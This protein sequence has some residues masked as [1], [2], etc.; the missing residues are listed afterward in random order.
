MATSR[1]L[2]RGDLKPANIKVTPDGKIKV[3]DFGLAKAFAGDGADAGV[4]NSPTLSM[5]A[6]QQGVILGTAAYMSPEQAR[7]ESTDKR[8]DIW[9]FGVVLF[10]MLTGRGTFDGRTVSDVLA[11]VLRADPDWRG[12]PS[13]LHPR[14]QFLL[15]RCLEKESK[16]R[17]GDIS[18][19][20]V[21]IQHVLADPDGVIVQPVTEVVQ[22]SQQ[23]KLRWVA[24]VVLTGAVAVI[25][26]W[27]LTPPPTPGPVSRWAYELVGG[28]NNA[29][30]LKS[31]LS[32]SPDGTHF[33]YSTIEGIYLRAVDRLDAG[34][35]P[36]TEGG[37]NPFF[38]PDGQSVG[39]WRNGQIETIPISGGRPSPVGSAP[40][41][42]SASWES[43]DMIL[44]A[45]YGGVYGLPASGGSPERIIESAAGE[46]FESPRLLPDG[47]GIL[48]SIS[49]GEDWDNA[50]IVVQ[51]L[52]AAERTIVLRGSDARYVSTGH[53]IYALD[54]GLYAIGFDLETLETIGSAEL[55][56]QGLS[57]ALASAS[58]NYGVSATGTL[59]YLEGGGSV[60]AGAVGALVWVNREGEEEAVGL[61][62]DS[63]YWTRLSSDG[64][65]L[66]LSIA[67]AGSGVQD[68][69]TSD[70]TR[71]PPT[72][73]KLT[74]TTSFDNMPIWTP[75]GEQ[76]VFASGRDGGLGFY[77]IHLGSGQV[78]HLIKG[79]TV[80]FLFPYDWSEDGA[81]LV[82]GYS[83]ADTGADVGVLS[84]EDLQWEPL[85]ATAANEW[86]PA[87]SPDGAWIAYT[88][89]R[90]SEPA[91]FVDSFPTPGDV[92]QISTGGGHAPLW[93]DDGRELFYRRNSDGAIITVSV[94]TGPIFGH[95]DPSVLIET[96]YA[97][98][99][100]GVPTVNYDYDT[101]R[102]RFLMVKEDTAAEEN[103]GSSAEPRIIVVQ[104]FFE[105]LKERV[106]VP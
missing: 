24:A 1:D 79:N 104:N 13:H 55:L 77:S 47:K 9:A 97:D 25:G 20:R 63:Y 27:R 50:Q 62:P 86:Q 94:E 29:S 105:E 99:G 45:Q 64:T 98:V 102:Q 101:Q 106:P 49:E 84:M 34:L 52:D 3:L 85:L 58:A 78:E 68:V 70:L 66:A 80:S 48:F 51:S 10:E 7:G 14:I 26:T 71:D 60:R 69:W 100:V 67:D 40:Q 88:S 43:D 74:N 39:F 32:V 42:L 59:V 82:F 72:L 23:S 95:A 15:E 65:R 38:S 5:A 61:Q 35:L 91:V 56:E 44:I 54:D 53:L 90:N 4:S 83:S 93:S 73:T 92:R 81:T 22:A 87:I 30:R 46:Q 8:A 96:E 18:D 103:D 33:V 89:D 2:S 21:D 19:A 12:L 76:L 11:G 28:T 37:V 6:T 17:Y 16:D 41:L 75:D 36:R 31:R 57:R